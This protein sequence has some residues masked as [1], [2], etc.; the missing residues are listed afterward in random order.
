MRSSAAKRWMGLVA[1]IL[2][3]PAWELSRFVD[4]NLLLPLTPHHLR[5]IIV[6]A[7]LLVSAWAL[8]R[9]WRFPRRSTSNSLARKTA[10]WAG[11]FVTLASAGI[12]LASGFV[13]V[14]YTDARSFLI[15]ANGGVGVLDR[16][17]SPDRYYY[18]TPG[19]RVAFRQEWSFFDP[20]EYGNWTFELSGSPATIL[21]PLWLLPFLFGWPTALLWWLDR[22]PTTGCATCGYDLTGNTSGRCPECGEPF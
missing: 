20:P 10:K 9:W 4:R 19:F 18:F 11:L 7:T 17:A 16:S 12:W 1:S 3:V 6:A 5:W 8:R 15:N 13:Y 2:L 14:G 22:R 21:F